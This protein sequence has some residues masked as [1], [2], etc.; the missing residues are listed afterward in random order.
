M[1]VTRPHNAQTLNAPQRT[2]V[3]IL[4]ENLLSILSPVIAM[5]EKLK[6][7]KRSKVEICLSIGLSDLL[8]I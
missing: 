2:N 6:T 7:T 4:S 1:K 8:Y 3:V 5:R